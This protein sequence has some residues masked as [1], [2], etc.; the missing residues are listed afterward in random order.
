MPLDLHF[1]RLGEW[2]GLEDFEPTLRRAALAAFESQGKGD[3]EV[4]YTFVPVAE[5][6]IL[7]RDYLERDRSTDV[8][9]FDLG[10]GGSL[11]GDVYISPEVAAATAAE[12]GEIEQNEIL[13]LVVH[14][15]LHVAGLDHPEGPGRETAPMFT[16]QEELLR[17]IV[18]G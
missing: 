14:G 1:N 8:I 15:S 17:S 4:S 6:R 10:E 7:N 11:M 3:G 12:H 5:I 16:L 9:A 2:P 18:G 13:R